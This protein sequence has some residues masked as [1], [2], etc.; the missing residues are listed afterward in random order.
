MWADEESRLPFPVDPPP[1]L[2]LPGVERILTGRVC[3]MVLGRWVEV[4]PGINMTCNATRKQQMT[5]EEMEQDSENWG[6]SHG[7]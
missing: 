1:A 4:F 3:V 2:Q 6:K 7:L 5:G